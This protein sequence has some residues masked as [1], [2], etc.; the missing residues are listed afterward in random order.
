V[1]ARSSNNPYGPFLVSAC[2]VLVVAALYLANKVLIPLA[3]AI[4]LTFILAPVVIW[5]QRHGFKRVLPVTLV[6]LV[7]VVLL[8]GFFWI[9]LEE[10]SSLG[11]EISKNRER[12]LAKIDGMRAG[13]DGVLSRLS[14]L[15]GS[16]LDVTRKAVVPDT[17]RPKGAAEPMRVIVENAEPIGGLSWF[18]AVAGPLLELLVSAALVIMLV[19]FMLVRREDLRNRV[20]GLVGRGRVGI[21]TRALDEAAQRISRYLSTLLAINSGFGAIFAIMLFILGVPYAILWGFLTG[22]LRFV[23]YMGTWVSLLMPLTFSIAIA[24]TWT[25]PILM[26]VLFAALELTTANVIEPLLFSHSTGISQV[27]LLV[28][29]AFW[30]W[31]WGPIG[32]VMSTPLSVCLVVLG[33]Y[34]PQLEFFD[35]LLGDEPVLSPDVSYYQRLLAKDEDEATELVEEHL[36]REPVDSVY[37]RLLLPALVLARSDQERGQLPGEDQSNILRVTSD[38]L[39]SVTGPQQRIRRIAVEGIAEVQGI[40]PVRVQAIVIGCPARDELDKLPLQMLKQL[41]EVSGASVEVLSTKMLSGEVISGV[42]EQRPSAVCIASVGPGG[43][44]QTRLLCKRLSSQIPNLTIAVGRWSRDDNPDQV[45]ERLLE[46]GAGR[47][48]TSL[49]EMRDYLLPLLRASRDQPAVAPPAA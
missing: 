46:A 7:T 20:L 22:M 29:A 9:V 15:V 34:V 10:V 3:L 19:V 13:D 32:L 24:D 31:L 44:A 2:V 43:L 48:D 49:L 39:E 35:V 6:V 16:L 33:K 41:L 37:D 27:A 23:P 26:A 47:V 36:E 30:T 40:E 1:P 17:T 42:A 5:L 8:G 18:P 38:I 45:R 28:A 25:Q 4:L 21:T 11:D 12:I 14:N